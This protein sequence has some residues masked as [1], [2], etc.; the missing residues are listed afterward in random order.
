MPTAGDHHRRQRKMLNP[1][2]SIK[3]IRNLTP[4]FHSIAL[5]VRIHY[6][7][8]AGC[9]SPRIIFSRERRYA[10]LYLFGGREFGR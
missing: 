9:F 2:F 3:H 6:E 5:K 10:D 8:Y 1:V 7:D 4:L